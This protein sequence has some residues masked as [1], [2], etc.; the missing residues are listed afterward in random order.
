[1]SIADLYISLSG[2]PRNGSSSP[3]RRGCCWTPY[4]HATAA[5]EFCTCHLFSCHPGQTDTTLA[6]PAPKEAA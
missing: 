4:G 3:C 6:E 1:M 2:T 5:G